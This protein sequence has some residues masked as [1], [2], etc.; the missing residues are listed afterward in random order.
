MSC[1]PAV[2]ICRPILPISPRSASAGVNRCSWVIRVQPSHFDSSVHAKRFTHAV[3][4]LHPARHRRCVRELRNCPQF[5]HDR[6]PMTS[7]EHHSFFC[8][9][10]GF[11]QCWTLQHSINT[12]FGFCSVCIAS[13]GRSATPRPASPVWNSMNNRFT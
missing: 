13:A 12:S 10:S 4:S 3:R 9:R 2:K 1:H 8:H 6:Y 7:L 5:R 11:D